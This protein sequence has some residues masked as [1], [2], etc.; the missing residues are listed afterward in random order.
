MKI[1]L[2]LFCLYFI[3]K[4]D[5]SDD[6]S[7]RCFEPLDPGPCQYYS[8]KWYF[9]TKDE[10]CKEFYYGGCLGSRNRFDNKQQCI[11]QCLYKEHNP[12]SIPDL[13]LL[14]H[15]PAFCPD[16]R[17]G[18]W[19]YYFNANTGECEKFYYYGCGG[20][21]NKFYSL[22]QCRKVCGERLAPQ[23][24]CDKCDVRTS[25]CKQHSK[26][27]YT[28]ECHQGFKKDQ[29]NNCIDVDE[30]RDKGQNDCHADAWCTNIVGSYSCSCKVG[31]VGDGRKECTYVGLGKSTDD[32]SKCSE[33]A[34]CSKGVCQ[35]IK[36]YKGDGFICEDV[37]ECLSA[38]FPCDRNA[39]CSNTN[40]SF[41]CECIKGYAGN[42]Y[43]CTT[44]RRSCL[45][46]Y[47]EGYSEQCGAGDWR[48]NYYYDHATKRCTLFWY[49]GCDGTSRNIFND[50]G[51][52][53]NICENSGVLGKAEV[54]WDKFDVNYRN[55]CLSGRWQQRYYFD[56]AT[57][58]CKLFW[59]DGC[60]GDSRNMFEDLLTCQWLCEETPKY[61][62]KACLEDFDDRYREECNGGRWRQ[63]F[64]YNKKTRKCTSFWYDGCKGDS[65]N[66]FQDEETCHEMCE[67]PG[68]ND[69]KFRKKIFHLKKD[70]LGSDINFPVHLHVV[71]HKEDKHTTIKENEK[72]FV[73]EK[74]ITNPCDISN[75]C[76]NNGSCFF[77]S[78]KQKTY[79]KCAPGYFNEHCTDYNDTDPC[80]KN[81]CQNG[82][83]CEK[84]N[85]TKS[86][87]EC[88][89]PKRLAGINCELKPCDPNPCL[90]G[91]IC[92]TTRGSNTFFCD[93]INN[94]GGKIC[95]HI[96]GVTKEPEYGKNVKLISSGNPEWVE[97]MKKTLAKN[98]ER[99]NTLI[100]SSVNETISDNELETSHA[101]ISGPAA[102]VGGKDGGA[103]TKSSIKN[104]FTFL[105]IFIIYL[106]ISLLHI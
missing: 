7:D 69:G 63:Q 64:F 39:E 77:D 37:N 8:T 103:L 61:K 65:Q 97:E 11:K 74:S 80:F 46:K 58:T 55:Q 42:G 93:C 50:I 23:V 95:D 29:F 106:A 75:P 12:A 26:F 73:T 30:C 94:Y 68:M 84:T 96:I 91:G 104:S 79:C 83:T 56:H 13:C 48:E 51:T 24:A 54:C 2:L 76:Q 1:F 59:Y 16:D 18:Q 28:C 102:Q 19:W 38:P 57:L 100:E 22:Y 62:I 99:N 81:P 60:K 32:C 9:D 20:N 15:D 71:T 52:C 105:T 31:Y 90:N 10:S 88:L 53:E 47:N 70:K 4:I 27:N 33:H 21:N 41:I 5:T 3:K 45:D 72:T 25:Y 34:T 6:G 92:R 85:K 86:G 87:Y 43:H 35:C 17:I 14:D 89:C 101:T 36:G 66:I 98:R 82:G 67:R 44:D 78:N 49:D 40:G